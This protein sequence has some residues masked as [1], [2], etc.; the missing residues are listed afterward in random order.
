MCCVSLKHHQIV[1]LLTENIKVI[2]SI[3]RSTVSNE[4]RLFWVLLT[5][6]PFCKFSG[7]ESGHA[8]ASSMVGSDLLSILCWTLCF[9]Q[10]IIKVGHWYKID[11]P[12]ILYINYANIIIILILIFSVD[13]DDCSSGLLIY[14]WISLERYSLFVPEGHFVC[15]NRLKLKW[16]YIFKG[17][18]I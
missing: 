9:F 14:I 2:V 10:S 5:A 8:K 12:T 7:E 13:L 6:S 18:Y 15:W 1:T 3:I 17:L 4:I 16:N 11:Y